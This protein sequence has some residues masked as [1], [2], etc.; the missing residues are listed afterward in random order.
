MSSNQPQEPSRQVLSVAELAAAMT[1]LPDWQL[2]QSDGT[3]LRRTYAFKSFEE[4]I[5]FMQGAAPA[6]S[7]LNHHPDWRN[8]Y[9]KLEVALTTFDRQRQIT[10]LDITLAKTL[11]AIFAGFLERL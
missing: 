2:D 6:I 1:D 10:Q 5:R 3:W 8:N 4:V 7:K 11:D 9:K